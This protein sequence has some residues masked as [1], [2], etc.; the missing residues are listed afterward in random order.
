MNSHYFRRFLA[1]S[2]LR[3]RHRN[4]DQ[5]TA[6]LIE[7]EHWPVDVL[8]TWQLEQLKKF[9][10]HCYENVPFYSER[11][12]EARFNPHT[13]EHLSQIEAIPV[14]TKTDIRG[15][16]ERMTAN[17][18]DLKTLS[19]GSTGGSTGVPVVF[20]KDEYVR[21]YD[22]AS[23]WRHMAWAGIE[24]GDPILRVGGQAYVKSRK[25]RLFAKSQAYTMNFTSRTVASVTDEYLDTI[26]EYMQTKKPVAMWG[27]ASGVYLIARHFL[28]RGEKPKHL[29]AVFT[30]SEVLQDFHRETI[31]EAF[32]LSPFDGYGGGDTGVA[33]ECREHN[34]MHTND[35]HRYI[36]LVNEEGKAVAHGEYGRVVV[37]NFLNRSWPYV[38]YDMG[39]LALAL[40]YEPCACGMTL[41]KIGTVQGRTGDFIRTI[42]G[43]TATTPNFTLVFRYIFKE[44]KTYQ[45][46]QEKLEAV[47]VRVVPTELYTQE[48]NDHILRSF[49]KILGDNI[50]IQLVLVEDVEVTRAGKRRIVISRL[51]Q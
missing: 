28:K 14:L 27:Y 47:I 35:S 9:L 30:T 16:Y 36:E 33:C 23:V 7:R 21:S 49:R 48:T 12:E 18:V 1:K 42:D 37:T 50:D 34:G 43:K 2:F 13:F 26:V 11:F 15:N 29:K 3:Y 45:I 31:R 41:P 20:F 19:K 22:A 39:D 46:V 25:K 40:P 24:P 51:A 6:E 8:R 32:G 5:V 10:V 44:V 4:F 17:G 38:R